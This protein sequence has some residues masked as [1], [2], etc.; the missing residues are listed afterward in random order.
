MIVNF[1]REKALSLVVLESQIMHIDAF[2]F[3]HTVKY[4]KYTEISKKLN[5]LNKNHL[6]N[7]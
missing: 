2:F 1:Q 3:C 4:M 6:Q 7:K 5:I